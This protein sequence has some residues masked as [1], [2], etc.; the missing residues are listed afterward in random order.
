MVSMDIHGKCHGDV[1]L[2]EPKT[3]ATTSAVDLIAPAHQYADDGRG[4]NW[5]ID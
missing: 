3:T 4:T 5:S 1:E 2:P